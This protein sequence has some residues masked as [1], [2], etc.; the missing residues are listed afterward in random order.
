MPRNRSDLELAIGRLI[1]K[2]QQAWNDECGSPEAEETMSVLCRCHNLLQ[3][4]KAGELT[5]ALKGR[6]L[7]GYIGGLWLGIHPKV[8]PSVEEAAKAMAKASQ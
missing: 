8:A 2:V 4:A 5:D 7:A 1:V 3:A 6:T